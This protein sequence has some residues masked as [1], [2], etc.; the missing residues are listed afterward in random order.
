MV[1]S[2]SPS[3]QE[4]Q[5]IFARTPCWYFMLYENVNKQCL[6]FKGLLPH[7]ILRNWKKAAQ[8]SVH[9]HKF[10][11]PHFLLQM[12]ANQSSSL[13]Y[14]S[15]QFC[16]NSTTPPLPQVV[17]KLKLYIRVHNSSVK[18]KAIPLQA[19]TGPEGSRRLRLSDFKK[20]GTW[21]W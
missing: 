11:Y 16:V 2:L 7:T 3:S 18:S 20:I 1:H 15:Y 6:F 9:R 21:M 13:A 10:T 5:K 4:V 17:K 12:L 8:V 14:C 19:W